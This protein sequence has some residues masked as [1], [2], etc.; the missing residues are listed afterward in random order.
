MFD[1]KTKCRGLW[2]GYSPKIYDSN[3]CE[4]NKRVLET[5]F[6]GATIISDQ[7]YEAFSKKAK[8]LTIITP[9]PEK[10]KA[11]TNLPHHQVSPTNKQI[12]R[13]KRIRTLRARVENPF[14]KIDKKCK[15]LTKPWKEAPEQLDALVYF[16]FGILNKN[17]K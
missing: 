9:S 5:T 3:W 4:V 16:A 8:S 1:G 2:G 13:N 14:G 7:H 17:I 6:K 11:M 10:K 12:A 15:S